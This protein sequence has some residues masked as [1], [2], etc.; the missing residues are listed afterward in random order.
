[1]E[2]A[3][4][5]YAHRP[6]RSPTAAPSA[7]VRHRP[8]NTALYNLV[9][10]YAEAFFARMGEEGASLPAFVLDEFERYLRCGRLEE[11]FLRVVCTGCRHEHLVAFS[12]KCRGFCPSCGARRMVESAA[13]LVDHVLPHVPSACSP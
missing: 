9:E 3:R 7:Y 2:L 1:M 12:C 8:E 13:G 6:G 4:S 5:Q 11:G 10:E